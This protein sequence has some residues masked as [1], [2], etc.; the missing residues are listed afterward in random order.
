GLNSPFRINRVDHKIE[1]DD[2][3]NPQSKKVD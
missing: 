1:P 3:R 2:L